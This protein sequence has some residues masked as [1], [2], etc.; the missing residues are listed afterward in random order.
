MNFKRIELYGFKSFADKT[1][2]NFEEGITGI[3]GPNGCGKSN[4]ADSVR[5]VLGEQSAK[6][7]RGKNMQ[8]VIFNGTEKRRL[9]SYCEV[10]LVFNNEKR[11]FPIETDEVIITRKL[12]RSGN[13]EYLLNRQL[14]RLSDILD[15][16]RDTGAGKEGYSII[17]QGKIDGILSSKP[18]ERRHIFEEAAGISKHK[19]KK[20]IAER[21]LERTS[22]NLNRLNDICSVMEKQLKPLADQAAKLDTYTE[23]ST[24]LKEQEVNLYLY[25]YEHATDRK[26]KLQQI[27][28]EASEQ[29]NVCRAMNEENDVKYMRTKEELDTIDVAINTMREERTQ[30]LVRKQK[31]SGE[32]NTYA[33]SLQHKQEERTRHES[34]VKSRSE[35]IESKSERLAVLLK[36]M[37][38]IDAQ[39]EVTKTDFRAAADRYIA[40][41]RE[42]DTREKEME[43]R[44]Q[45]IVTNLEEL[46]KL[47]AD[48]SG[49]KTECEALNERIK[50]LDFAGKTSKELLEK[51]E[52][53]AAT[54]E[55]K[56]LALE[57]EKEKLSADLN[58]T[59]DA[60]NGKIKEINDL[61]QS[62]HDLNGRINTLETL[63]KMKLAA[64]NDYEGY[65]NAVKYL[66]RDAKNDRT[67]SD[68]ICGV[69]TELIKVDKD[70]ELAIEMALGKTLQNI[71]VKKEEDA[72]SIINYLKDKRYGRV[73][74]LPMS[75]IKSQ[76]LSRREILR[77]KGVL[78]VAS[79]LVHF[80]E[81]YRDIMEGLLGRILITETIDDAIAIT[82]KYREFHKIVTLGGE[83]FNNFGSITGGNK[84]D[85]SQNLLGLERELAQM[86]EN[87]AQAS[88]Q[89]DKAS[90]DVHNATKL[91][92]QMSL[93]IKKSD[94]ALRD[95]DIQIAALNENLK[96]CERRISEELSKISDMSAERD[97][98]KSRMDEVS[99]KI[100][101]CDR[102]QNEFDAEKSQNNEG[103]G[104][105]KEE[106]N[107]LK[108][109]ATKQG[110]E[111]TRLQLTLSNLE[112]E[113]KSGEEEFSRLKRD[114]AGA[115]N[116]V[117]E[118]RSALA[119][120]AAEIERTEKALLTSS[121]SKDD[122]ERLGELEERLKN[123]ETRKE[124]LN[125]ILLEIEQSRKIFYE[126]NE[127][128]NAKLTKAESD[129]A[130]V[131]SDLDNM[132][133]RIDEMYH[134]DY[135]KA[136]EF[137]SQDFKADAAPPL[138]NRLKRK[139]NELGPIN[140]EAKE[141]LYQL[142]QEY[143]FNITQK[144]DLEKAVADLKRIIADLTAEM[145]EKFQ[146]AFEEINK[147]FTV[148]FKELFNGGKGKLVLTDD[149]DDPLEA[150]I[151]IYAE[152][153]GKKLQNITLLSGGEKA[154]T[155][156]GILFAILRL[157]PMPFCILDEIEA[158]LDDSN[159]KLFA[160][161]L[162]R[163]SKE[164]QFI[165][166]THRK[167]TMELA[168]VLYGVTME[169]KGVSKIV[170]VRLE[171]AVKISSE[172]TRG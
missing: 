38:E 92:E 8:D 6:A 165:V 58:K 9:L 160:Q 19:N 137:K 152:P 114:C 88:K 70:Y 166:I 3:V 14:C 109:A 141:A 23:Y 161:Y 163:F 117:N 78:G 31:L 154:L 39:L 135:E 144:E 89:Y 7:L 17:G 91:T 113:K 119:L 102:L 97:T 157:R 11:M 1:V 32:K 125:R 147:N 112:N 94:T 124:E 60:Y 84:N 155:A 56:K 101:L 48:L 110:E 75:A 116:D 136:L 96:A 30:L 129:L 2:I 51:E 153:P 54:F 168:D 150:G 64:K 15:L 10:S 151:E 142:N 148:I 24:Q 98:L 86:K 170:T 111:R 16:M 26:A 158:A 130:R 53:C 80:D 132:K 67:L 123:I 76:T 171:D 42:V 72:K 127:R 121:I 43:S 77:E 118:S 167:P 73:T 99:E 122:L 36:R 134:L 172:A 149:S 12:Y 74:F 49:L 34:I 82:R 126:T 90:V 25:Q 33:Q 37:Q 4:V 169:E 146:T 106:L 81:K 20:L 164:T 128:E 105:F 87:I 162:H 18:D 50:D 108:D 140:P 35:E 27:A 66:M 139:I 57:K 83:V 46:G 59:S 93:E 131:D 55:Q 62:M 41:S 65:Q 156:I 45:L 40:L 115:Q 5:W 104:K 79:E 145:V 107:A 44:N 47:K 100:A 22:E 68:K 138:I 85:N 71:V 143:E 63:Y 103:V 21:K 13:S 61:K 69:V 52:V 28:D 120:L 95:T 29:L 133:A 159:A